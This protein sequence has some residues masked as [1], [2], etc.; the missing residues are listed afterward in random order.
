MGTL[1]NIVLHYIHPLEY[2]T[3]L[4]IP[5]RTPRTIT[6]EAR[7]PDPQYKTIKLFIFYTST[8][9]YFHIDTNLPSS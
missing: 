8:P 5:I 1:L 7:H 4:C 2:K 9:F 3:I 6:L